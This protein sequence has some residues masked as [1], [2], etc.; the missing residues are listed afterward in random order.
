MTAKIKGLVIGGSSGSWLVEQRIDLGE[1]F[2][3]T[4][5]PDSFKNRVGQEIIDRMIDRIREG[6]SVH[7][8]NMKAYDPDYVDSDEFK[9][10][11]K[12]K[13]NVNMRLTGDMLNLMDIKG[14][15]GDT[16]IVGWNDQESNDKAHGHMTGFQGKGTKREFFGATQ[17]LLEEIRDEYASEVTPQNDRQQ[18]SNSSSLTALD[19]L[20]RAQTEESRSSTITLNRLFGDFGNDE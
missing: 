1:L 17:K 20:R 11:G 6:D 3:A 15:E 12:S 7:G 9:A 19:I 5:L 8:R 13:S 10:Y 14:I 4:G 2:E 18:E 16:V